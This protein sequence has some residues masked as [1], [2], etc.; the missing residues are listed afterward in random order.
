MR[1]E[2]ARRLALSCLIVS[3]A[4]GLSGAGR[5]GEVPW[6]AY[7]GAN[8]QAADW[9]GFVRGVGREQ[10]SD[11]RAALAG[12]AAAAFEPALAQ[13][14]Q[15]A[16]ERD[17]ILPVGG[18]LAAQEPEEAKSFLRAMADDRGAAWR[19]AV[20][21][22]AMLAARV[23]DPDRLYWQIG[24]EINSRRYARAFGADAERARPDAEFVAP[25]Y[26]ERYF[27]PSVAGLMRASRELYGDERRI[28]VALGSIAGAY[29]PASIA[30]LE[31]LLSYRLR[32]DYAP[33]LA[34]RQVSELIDLIAIHYLLT[35]GDERWD[36][37]LSGLRA[38]WVGQGRISGVWATEEL[39]LKMAE[40]ELG[41]AAAVKAAGR[42][43]DYG[44]A[45]ALGPREF[46]CGLWGW[47]IGRAGGRGDDAMALLKGFVG[48]APLRRSEGALALEGDPQLEWRSFETTTGP[49]RYVVAVFAKA[50]RGRGEVS[51][52]RSGASTHPMRVVAHVFGADPPRAADFVVSE[53]EPPRRIVRRLA[54]PPDGAALLLVEPIERA[55][56]G[57]QGGRS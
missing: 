17:V 21:R 50:K 41:A 22:Q 33:E 2:S 56:A 32:G 45:N 3:L 54:I 48:A 18:L 24:N 53:V 35:H 37:T 39:G 7:I 42:C 4:S 49:R 44:L 29:R 43:L 23:A 46:R 13:L 6:A 25:L 16:G 57:L 52:S 15:L 36:E 9:A 10:V 31:A 5:A 11:W 34:G 20:H 38:R 12:N 51:L 27:A 19:S 47:W 30:W 28:R 26:A 8:R 14:G 40:A 55:A 1:I